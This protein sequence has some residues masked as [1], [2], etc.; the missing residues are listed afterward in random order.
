MSAILQ[1]GGRG[2]ESLSAHPTRYFNRFPKI[3]S[4]AQSFGVSSI[5]R[6]EHKRC[7]LISESVDF[8]PQALGD[9]GCWGLIRL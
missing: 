5:N 7:M 4:R 1:A 2:F 9:F 3:E 8:T 6:S